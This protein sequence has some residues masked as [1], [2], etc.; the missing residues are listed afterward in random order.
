MSTTRQS[1]PV[2]GLVVGSLLVVAVVVVVAFNAFNGAPL[3][4]E[5]P[6]A[7]TT[8]T[9]TSKAA[10]PTTEAATSTPIVVTATSGPTGTTQ[11]TQPPP[12]AT[13][14]PQATANITI[15]ATAETAVVV[16][17]GGNTELGPFLV[18]VNGMTLYTF[19]QDTPTT[20]ACTGECIN[21]WPPLI[22]PP[23]TQ[24]AAGE[25]VTGQL[26]TITRDDGTLQVTYNGHPLYHYKQDIAPG[27][28]KGQG[29]ANMWYVAAP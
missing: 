21:N 11:P 5:T 25:G 23:G 19:S 28:A 10:T 27:D 6:T 9:T 26:A 4:T 16:K 7:T 22:V 24:L 14:T 8:P 17:L 29:V 12:T 18:D 3:A 1:L 15:T 2:V 20:S 13:L